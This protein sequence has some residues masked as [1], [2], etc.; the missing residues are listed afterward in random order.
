MISSGTYPEFMAMFFAEKGYSLIP[1]RDDKSPVIEWKPNQTTRAGVNLVRGWVNAGH[2][3]GIV[4]GR[5][6]GLVVLDFDEPTLWEQFRADLP[7][8]AQQLLLIRTR[9]GYHAYLAVGRAGDPI[10]S[11]K[12]DGLDMQADGRYV[13]APASTIG[14]HRYVRAAGP[15]QYSAPMIE[16]GLKRVVRWIQQR[17]QQPTTPAIPEPT[18]IPDERLSLEIIEAY[19][20]AW[21]GR[22]RNNALFAA[23]RLAHDHFYNED[24]SRDALLPAFLFASV[25][26]ENPAR[27]EREARATIASAFKRPRR[28]IR[29]VAFKQLPN[30]IRE[31]MNGRKL[32]AVARTFDALRESGI[33]ANAL[34]SYTVARTLLSGVVGDYSIRQFFAFLNLHC[35][36]RTLRFAKSGLTPR[37]TNC[38]CIGSKNQRKLGR[39]EKAYQLP[40]DSQLAGWL[41]IKQGIA[42]DALKT[43]EFKTV[44]TYRGA[45]YREHIKRKAGQHSL[46]MLAGRMG[47]TKQT[48]RNYNSIEG[49]KSVAQYG[50]MLIKWSNINLMGEPEQFYNLDGKLRTRAVFI[51]TNGQR[52]PA[53]ASIAVKHLR[54]GLKPVLKWQQMNYYYHKSQWEKGVEAYKFATNA[55]KAKPDAHQLDMWGKMY[56]ASSEAAAPRVNADSPGNAP[57]Q[58]QRAKRH[59]AKRH[60]LP[61][62]QRH[63]YKQPLPDTAAESLAQTIVKDI[64]GITI[65]TARRIVHICPPRRIYRALRHVANAKRF[66]TPAAIFAIESGFTAATRRQAEEKKQRMVTNARR[67]TRLNSK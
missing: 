7:D 45:L 20:Q 40:D 38:I 55:P 22:G 30:I 17:G 65:N 14:G 23:A 49:I 39:R 12:V 50:D 58:Q 48:I 29:R 13:V 53:L 33:G 61:A 47:V 60:Q 24:D 4:T 32:T 59:I 18:P 66:H 52:Y 1:I 37:D 63:I 31:A 9:R 16:G 27:R 42:S 64:K 11:L 34:I 43:G 57:R 36:P 56:P 10:P 44:R 3:L 67:R 28:P 51:V 46:K 19:Y 21:Q 2:Q 62:H 54:A 25:R 35:S 8:V 15:T 6:S 5:I 26:G 41:G